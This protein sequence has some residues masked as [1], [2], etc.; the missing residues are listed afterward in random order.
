MSSNRRLFLPIFSISTLL[1]TY[2]ALRELPVAKV[3]VFSNSVEQLPAHAEPPALEQPQMPEEPVEQES[4]ANSSAPKSATQAFLDLIEE[5]AAPEEV[6]Q[7]PGTH[8]I[9]NKIDGNWVTQGDMLVDPKKIVKDIG[10][11]DTRFVNID[12]VDLWPNNVVPYRIEP[13]LD[14]TPI[15]KAISLINQQTNLRFVPHRGEQ[16]LVFFRKYKEERC[17]SHLGRIGGSQDILLNP[18]RCGYANIL[19]EMVHAIGLVHEHSREDRDQYVTIHWDQIV[20]GARHQFQKMAAHISMLTELPFDFDSI[21][22]YPSRNSFGVG[23]N[24]TLT[25]LDGTLLNANRVG[26]SPGDI[27]KINALYPKEDP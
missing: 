2:I 21:M 25:K 5:A 9:A 22:L 8:F 7:K 10:D 6:F 27:A 15:L 12:T 17:L 23:S 16:D 24:P 1:I 14:P 18:V 20:E 19:H 26:L 13:T 3:V 4:P 11:K